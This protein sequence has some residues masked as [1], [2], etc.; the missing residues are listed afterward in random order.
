MTDDRDKPRRTVTSV[1]IHSWPYGVDKWIEVIYEGEYCK[2]INVAYG[3]PS[4]YE[5]IDRAAIDVGAR[6]HSFGIITEGLGVS[7]VEH[8]EPKVEPRL[9]DLGY[10]LRRL[11]RV[12]LVVVFGAHQLL[13]LERERGVLL[14]QQ[15]HHGAGELV[16]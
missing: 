9:G 14:H 2:A 10:V 3:G 5:S 7:F 4:R 8:D 13:E 6:L 12:G 11:G 15:I 16:G 1:A